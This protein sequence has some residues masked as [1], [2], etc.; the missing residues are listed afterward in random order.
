LSNID[1]LR[2]TFRIGNSHH[3]VQNSAGPLGN[4]EDEFEDM[5]MRN[6]QYEDYGNY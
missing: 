4:V 5:I 1:N 6:L 2:N 3:L